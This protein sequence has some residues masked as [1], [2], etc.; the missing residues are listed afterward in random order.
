[1]IGVY[2]PAIEEWSGVFVEGR[3]RC[4][5]KHLIKLFTLLIIFELESLDLK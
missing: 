4:V 2:L 5:E 1:M 3:W